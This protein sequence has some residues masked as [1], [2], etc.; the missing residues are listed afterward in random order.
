MYEIHYSIGKQPNCSMRTRLEFDDEISLE[1]VPNH[2]AIYLYLTVKEGP[3]TIRK[4]SV[5]GDNFRLCEDGQGTHYLVDS[6]FIRI[7]LR[8]GVEGPIQGSLVIEFEGLPPFCCSLAIPVGASNNSASSGGNFQNFRDQHKEGEANT[9]NTV[10]LLRDLQRVLLTHGNLSKLDREFIV[11]LLDK[12]MRTQFS[13]LREFAD[14]EEV[15]NAIQEVNNKLWTNDNVLLNLKA[16]EDFMRYLREIFR[17]CYIDLQ[18]KCKGRKPGEHR[19]APRDPQELDRLPFNRNADGHIESP[20]V[21]RP[22][23]S[24]AFATLDAKEVTLLRLRYLRNLKEGEQLRTEMN[25]N[26][27]GKYATANAATQ[28][29]LRAKDEFASNLSNEFWTLVVSGNSQV[30]DALIDHFCTALEIETDAVVKG[31]RNCVDWMLGD[32]KW[33]P[34]EGDNSA[35]PIWPPEE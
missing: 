9:N 18:R 5:G 16:P 15:D 17:N 27:Q 3:I 34:P 33:I 21:L 13:T 30:D 22:M 31:K 23:F 11:E 20:D 25:A 8:N 24:T 7:R 26:H 35:L 19:M 28:A 12:R 1:H 10:I 29:V 2:D 6:P 32:A 14:K 4:V